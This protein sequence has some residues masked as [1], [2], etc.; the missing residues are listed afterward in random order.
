MSDNNDITRKLI[1]ESM[2]NTSDEFTDRIMGKIERSSSPAPIPSWHLYVFICS[3]VMVCG[4][5][6]FSNDLVSHIF[7]TVDIDL[8]FPPM[9]FQILLIVFVLLA[10]NKFLSLKEEAR[11]M[12]HNKKLA[13]RQRKMIR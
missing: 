10:I 1:K 7:S 11:K 13:V 4:S 5:L 2:L 12:W 6:F 8:E 3:L 9:S